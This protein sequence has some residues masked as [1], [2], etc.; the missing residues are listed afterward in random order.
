MI[1]LLKILLAEFRSN[2][3]QTANNIPRNCEFPKL[4]QKIKVALGMRRVG[5]TQ[6]I[7]QTIRELIQEKGIPYQQILYINFEDDRLFPSDQKQLRELL[8]GFYSLYPDNHDQ[9]CYFFLDEIQNVDDW[10]MVIRRFFDSKKIQIYLTGSSA[11]LL[12][13][14]IATS[15]RGRAINLEIWPLSFEEY[16]CAHQVK[17]EEELF[18]QKSRDLLLEH[19]QNYL[20][21]GGFPETIFATESDRRQILQSYVELVII[22]DIV[23]RYEIK[24]IALI[25]YLINF[26]LK[27]PAS[28]FSINKF[29]NDLKSQGISGSRNTLYDYMH[30]IE[31]AYLAFSVPLFSES[32]RKVQ[33][34][35]KKL[36]TVDPGLVRAFSF[37]INDNHG[38]LFENMI[39]LDLR[40]SGHKIYYYLTKERYE[41]DFLTEDKLGRQHM[42]QVVWDDSDEKTMERETR[43]LKAAESELNIKG[44]IIT[45]YNYIEK[46]WGNLLGKSTDFL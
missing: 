7:F 35:P 30:Y 38:H 34:N 12:S 18:G 24:N 45:P 32:I 14:E 26:V 27:N 33:S 37:S 42:Y 25:K 2:F 22:R 28:T 3:D 5:K 40:R 17:P 6:F 1:D 16:L 23:E 31:D 29:A 20:H 44:S 13:K 8:E 46:I 19:L 4:P 11:K 43:A 36:Y 41:I 39:F 15:L 10:A 21:Q 9:T